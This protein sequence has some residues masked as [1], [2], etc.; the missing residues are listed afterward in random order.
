M[1][2][3]VLTVGILFLSALIFFAQ[4]RLNRQERDILGSLHEQEALT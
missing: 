3:V 4:R 1:R 2:T